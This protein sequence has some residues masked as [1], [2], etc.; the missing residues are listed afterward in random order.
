MLRMTEKNVQND[1]IKK[2]DYI[3]ITVRARKRKD[4][5]GNLCK[6]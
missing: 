3:K 5:Q 1:V 6:F 2:V 4:M